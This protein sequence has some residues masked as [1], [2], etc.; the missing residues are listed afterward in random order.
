MS[1]RTKYLLLLAI[2]FLTGLAVY[3]GG[4]IWF[5]LMLALVPVGFW[6]G[7]KAPRLPSRERTINMCAVLLGLA[8]LLAYRFLKLSE[9][10]LYLAYILFGIAILTGL[11][12]DIL[13]W[14]GIRRCP[15]SQ[16]QSND[17]PAGGDG[18]APTQ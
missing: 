12:H 3:M 10:V 8:T 6:P 9:S 15:E 11:R 13:V 18:Q 17:V 2:I 1:V 7:P 16:A 5:L 14:R 4:E